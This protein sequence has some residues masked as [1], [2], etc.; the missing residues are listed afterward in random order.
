MK[1]LKILTPALAA[2]LAACSFHMDPDKH[3]RKFFNEGKDMIVSALKKQ[4]VPDATIDSARTTLDRHEKTVTGEIANVLRQQRSL[5]RG[6]STGLGEDRLVALEAD[7][8]RANEKATR[9][10]GRMH[11]ELAKVVGDQTWKRVIASL[12]KRASRHLGN[13][14]R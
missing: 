11:D 9:D 13:E 12:D 5:L 10:I 8:H 1:A 3:A 2:L 4:D 7:L 14:G 6:I